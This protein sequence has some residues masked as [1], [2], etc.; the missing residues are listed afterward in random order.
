MLIRLGLS[1]DIKR[2]HVEQ[3]LTGLLSSAKLGKPMDI[4]RKHYVLI[5]TLS[6][7]LF[8]YLVLHPF[9]MIGNEF[10]HGH[11]M[12]H[13]GLTC[14]AILDSLGDSFSLRSGGVFLWF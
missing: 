6:G 4:L 14:A 10:F 2:C 1:N 13:P 7:A 9:V 5:T 12:M 3:G 11:A 8:G